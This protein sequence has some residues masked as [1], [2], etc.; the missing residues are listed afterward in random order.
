MSSVCENVIPY[1][2]WYIKL[3]KPFLEHTYSELQYWW[4]VQ[5]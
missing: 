5:N 1:I 2:I 3:I 4:L